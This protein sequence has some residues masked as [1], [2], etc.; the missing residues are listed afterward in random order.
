MQK[1]KKI[2]FF[3]KFT[4]ENPLKRAGQFDGLKNYV[5]FGGLVKKSTYLIDMSFCR[6]F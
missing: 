2:D 1:K 5:Y 3:Q 4:L 6:L